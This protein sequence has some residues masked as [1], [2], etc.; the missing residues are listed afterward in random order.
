MAWSKVFTTSNSVTLGASWAV[1]KNAGGAASSVKSVKTD[2]STSGMC[3]AMTCKWIQ[4]TLRNGDL[5]SAGQLGS[6]QNIA[7]AHRVYR[8]DLAQTEAGDDIDNLM[9]TFGL[10]GTKRSAGTLQNKL[11]FLFETLAIPGMVY[12]SFSRPGGGHALGFKIATTG[13]YFFDPNQGLFKFGTQNDLLQVM[14][15]N[16]TTTYLQRYTGYSLRH[17]VAG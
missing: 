4:E 6:M 13:N 12:C 14:E 9:A 2:D 8:R 3:A 15:A 5:T 16:M 7:I 17:V 10:K 1:N 11:R